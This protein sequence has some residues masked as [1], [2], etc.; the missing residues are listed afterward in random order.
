MRRATLSFIL[1]AITFF[2]TGCPR[3]DTVR[4]FSTEQLKVQ[5]EFQVVLTK[6]FAAMEEY[7]ANEVVANSLYY[8]RL[9][10]G[11]DSSERIVKRQ[12]ARDIEKIKADP[13]L[14][15]D[16][17]L[18]AI[19]ARSRELGALLEAMRAENEK[20]KADLANTLQAYKDKNKEILVAYQGI[21]DA[22][23]Q[24][25]EYIQLKKFDEVIV[26]K[27]L[28]SVHANQTKVLGL[29][30]QAASLADKL[31]LKAKPEVGPTQ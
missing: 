21:L 19:A 8:D 20:D 23:N 24:L 12:G 15:L 29:F 2:S 10:K 4:K 14:S 27:L 3:Y 1:L 7:A 30:D 22:Q 26:E 31:K 25:N 11:G 9:L 6:Y 16:D 17:K 13:N 18:E 5:Q 28:G